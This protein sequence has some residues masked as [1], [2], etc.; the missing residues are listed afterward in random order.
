MWVAASYRGEARGLWINASPWEHSLVKFSLKW[1]WNLEGIFTL[2]KP[3]Q[4]GLSAASDENLCYLSPA[5]SGL[6]APWWY[7]NKAPQSL[8]HCHASVVWWAAMGNNTQ[9]LPCGKPVN[10]R[11]GHGSFIE[12]VLCCFSKS[13][14]NFKGHT[15]KQGKSEG[16]DSCDRSSNQT[17]I[18]FKSPIFRLCDLEI[19]WMSPKNN[20]ACLLYYIKL[21]VSFQIHQWIQAG[22]TVR[23]C[24]SWVKFDDFWAVWPC[25]LTY[26]LE[27]GKSEGFES[28]T[29]PIVRKCPFGSKSV[30]FCPVWP[31]NLMNDLG[32]Q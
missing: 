10:W 26:D 17:Q 5:T 25:N 2:W 12:E 28:C 32:K 13:S 11:L 22:V 18:G 4:C 3:W 21:C 30:M 29:R 8:A 6:P 14:I 31:W 9:D 23:K 16:F 1:I 27:Q 20:K 19:W 15:G 7:V 24:P